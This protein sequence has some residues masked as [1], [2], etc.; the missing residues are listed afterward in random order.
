MHCQLPLFNSSIAELSNQE[1]LEGRK[2][3]IFLPDLALTLWLGSLP[4]Q[5]EPRDFYEVSFLELGDGERVLP[6]W[7]VE[8]TVLLLT[9]LFQA[10]E[11][12]FSKDPA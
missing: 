11:G 7:P 8:S 10:N 4:E 9:G 3:C 12:S 1:R 2:G 6:A 5:A